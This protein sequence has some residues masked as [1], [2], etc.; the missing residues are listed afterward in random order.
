MQ[1]DYLKIKYLALIP[2]LTLSFIVREIKAN[3]LNIKQLNENI[4]DDS[5]NLKNPQTNGKELFQ[6]KFKNFIYLLSENIITAKVNNNSFE[7]LNIISNTQYNKGNK[8][9]AEGDVEISK[10]NMRLRSDKLVY[11][12]E[13]KIIILTGEIRFISDEQ[14]FQATEIKYN[15]NDKE[16]YIKDV[17]GTINFDSL[18]SINNNLNSGKENLTEFNNSIKNAKL[19]KSS[20]LEFDDITSPQNLKI[21]INQMTKW[22]FQS[23]EI[24]IKENIWSSEILYLTN[25]PFN[26]PQIII[27]NSK[28][29]SFEENG[30]Y[31]VKS[32]WSSIII[33]DKLKIPIGPRNYKSKSGSN[34]KWGIGYDWNNKDGLYLTRYPEPI[35]FGKSTINLENEFYIQRSLLGKTKSFSKENNSVLAEKVEQDSKITDYFGINADINSNILGLNFDSEIALNSLDLDKFKKI[36]KVKTEL[37]KVLHKSKTKDLE[38]DTK[39]SIFGIYRDSVWNGSIGEKDILT[40]YGLKI[41]KN[42]NWGDKKIS[43]SSKLAAGFGEYQSN[44]KSTKDDLISRERLNILWFRE[45]IYHILSSKDDSS[46]TKEFS[47]IPEPTNKGLDFL[48]SSKVDLYNYSEG[49]F[50]NLITLKAGPKITL[51]D[52]RKKYLDYSEISILGK[53]TIANGESP[54]DFDQS[55]DKHSIE[56]DLKQQLIGPLVLKYSTE[57]NLDVNSP[58]FHKFSKNNYELT[59]NRRAFNIGIFYDENRQAGGINFEINGFN[60]KGYGEKFIN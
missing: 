33:E 4:Y 22:R 9:I 56:I 19:N 49:E 27:K 45:H 17:Y 20:S 39:L 35:S 32:K 43:K 29:E 14:F 18:N 15:L 54:F 11:D 58:N 34:F 1:F 38:K 46:I 47:Y 52:F 10:N 24:K 36:I 5:V 51:G 31:T 2:F 26:T 57:Y 7:N 6:S 30:N 59:W 60:F 48:L 8:F 21:D 28:F 53:T 12:L 42:K 44:K 37:S 3:V 40:A 25:D 23:K 55:V 50:Q 16:G 41:E 13:K